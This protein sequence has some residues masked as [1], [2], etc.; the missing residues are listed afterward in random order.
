MVTACLCFNQFPKELGK[1]IKQQG[2]EIKGLVF[3]T[4]YILHK[5]SLHN[6]NQCGLW[7][8]TQIC[9]AIYVGIEIVAKYVA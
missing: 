5:V 6:H 3:T 7:S 9:R 4:M 8:T 2:S 1:V